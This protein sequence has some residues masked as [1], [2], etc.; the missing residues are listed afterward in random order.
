[1]GKP[2]LHNYQVNIPGLG[3][4]D[5]VLKIQKCSM[6][7][8]KTNAVLNSFVE[9]K[10]L[11]LSKTKC[12]RIHISKKKPG[13]IK[14]CMNLKIHDD[15]MVNSDREKYLGDL[16]D[17]TGRIRATIEERKTKGCALVAEIMA[18]L[19]EIPLGSHKM[20]IGLHLRQAMLINGILY[21]SEVWHAISE[22]EIRMLEMVDEHLLRSIVKGHSKTPLE[23]LYLEVGAMPIRFIQYIKCLYSAMKKSSC[24]I[25]CG[26]GWLMSEIISVQGSRIT[27]S[28]LYVRMLEMTNPTYWSALNCKAE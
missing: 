1:M 15:A 19:D 8:V 3:M 10:K 7:S 4:V 17:K 9:S 5:D 25:L 28:V 22:E 11:T 20:E 16:V 24:C 18:I 27:S 23:F 21:N 14:E 6:K 26:Q 2:L 12:H 13:S